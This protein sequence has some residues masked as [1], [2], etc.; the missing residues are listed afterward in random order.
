MMTELSL[1]S[2]QVF[3][4]AVAMAVLATI[5]VFLRLLAKK[6]TKTGLKADDVWILLGLA[7][8]WAYVGV[9]IWGKYAPLA[10]GLVLN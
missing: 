7:S 5:A 8:L 2:R 3:N 6:C 10:V 1:N 4:T 9:I